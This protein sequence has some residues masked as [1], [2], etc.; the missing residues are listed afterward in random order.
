MAS[1]DPWASCRRRGQ[2]DGHG[3]TRFAFT[4]YEN[5]RWWVGLDWTAALFHGER[6]S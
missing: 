2:H 5:K 3:K 6:P 4:V 1:P